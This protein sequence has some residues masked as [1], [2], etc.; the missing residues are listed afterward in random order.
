MAKKI[1]KENYIYM[2]IILLMVVIF[3]FVMKSDLINKILIFD[4]KVI[5]AIN[6]IVNST[7]TS[8]FRIITHFGDFYIP[9]VILV[10]ILVFLKNKWIFILQVC[11]Y[12]CAGIIIYLSKLL[13]ARPRPTDALINMP[14]TYSFPSGHTFTS[15]IFYMVLV[16]LLTYKMDSKKRTPLLVITF[17]FTML[18]AFSRIYLGVHYFSDIVGGIILAIPCVFMFINIIKKNFIGDKL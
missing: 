13:I 8:I 15:I 5:D 7:L 4:H 10:W 16:F 17:V 14:K 3:S 6:T 12:A 1:F 18:I 11:S 9:F 2:I